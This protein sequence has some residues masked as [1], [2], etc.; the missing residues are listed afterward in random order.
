MSRREPSRRSISTS[1]ASTVLPSGLVSS[2]RAYALVHKSTFGRSMA[3]RT[4]Q[5]SA[6][7]FA[8]TLHANELHVLQ[9]TQPSRMPSGSGDG[10][11]PCAR[12]CS[13]MVGHRVGVGNRRVWKRA[14]LGLGRVGA[15]LA[16]HVIQ[17]LGALV[18]RRERVVVDR[19][20]RRDPLHVLE[21]LKVFAA[22]AVQHAAPE[23]RVAA[24]VVMGVRAELLAAFVDP[25]LLRLIAKVLPDRFGAPVLGFL[26]D[27]IAALEDENARAGCRPARRPS[28]RRPRRCR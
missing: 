27:E 10:C 20:A 9:R 5:T 17:T 3:G 25:P 28:C 2:R 13:T 18:V 12:S 15:K 16:V 7:L 23:L 11:S 14:A 19:P 6:S 26:R 8:C 4:Q 21:R 24:D 22:Q 1:T